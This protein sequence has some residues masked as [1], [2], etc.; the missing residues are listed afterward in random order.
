MKHFEVFSAKQR[1]FAEE[2]LG[3]VMYV[4][5]E[6]RVSL[7]VRSETVEELGPG[8]VLGEMALIDGSPRTATATALTDCRLVALNGY[9]FEF[10]VKQE[11]RF[12]THLLKVMARRLRAANKKS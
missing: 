4:L 11:P 7:A 6:G 2:D 1:I 8:G 3:N 5:V 9:Q 12:A 10:L